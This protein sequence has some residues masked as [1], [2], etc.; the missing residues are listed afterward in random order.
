MNKFGL[1]MVSQWNTYNLTENTVKHIAPG[2]GFFI[3]LYRQLHLTQQAQCN[4]MKKC[5]KL[6]H[7]ETLMHLFANGSK[8]DNKE[9]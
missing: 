6:D 2:E 1:G 5:K 7:L 3:T 9:Y 8:I 4:L